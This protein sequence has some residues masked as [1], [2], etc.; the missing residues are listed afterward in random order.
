MT[1]ELKTLDRHVRRPT[2]PRLSRWVK[3]GLLVTAALAAILALVW[4][5]MPRPVLV[6]VAVARVGPLEVTV[7]EDGHT[8][9]RARYV[10][11]APITGMLE[12]ID[13]DAGAAI[14]RGTVVARIGA[15]DPVLLDPR[16]RDQAVAALAAAGARERTAAAGITRARAAHEVAVTEAGRTQT[17][18][19][20][21]AVAIAVREHDDLAAQVAAQDLAAAE[22]QHRAAMAD[23]EA[24]RAALHAGG[25]R[26]PTSVVAAPISGRILR[27]VR[28][29]A[30]PV[31]AGAPLLELGD[32]TDLEVVVDVLSSDGARITP[33]MPVAIAAWGGAH[34]LAGS[35]VRVEPS[36][37][38]R[39]SALGVEE[40][41]VNVIVA[42]ASPPPSLGD[43]FRVEARVLISRG[44]AL[45][46]PA[47]AVFR[48][49]G[50][51]SVYAIEHGRARL[52]HVELGRRG[53]LELEIAK[54]L[55]P[56]TE[57]ILHPSDRVADGAR[58][59]SGTVD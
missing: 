49:R 23:V 35:V 26:G 37:F 52:R 39:I 55:A 19:A 4:G 5:W 8:R 46:V 3:R 14:E 13:L 33:G 56:G 7:E 28:D 2:R 30:G 43:G 9:V 58:V 20:H 45:K 6:A 48:D 42:I 15:P 12:R 24:A 25:S 21:G 53:R 34:E 51:W 18:A 40:Q 44:D 54:G 38:T 57:V 10:V 41:R 59:E 31:A 47:S 27:V 16:S 17:L 1:T 32:P 11:S 29:S 22:A 36:A 50:E